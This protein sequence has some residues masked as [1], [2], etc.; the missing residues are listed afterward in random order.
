[1]RV[2][3]GEKPYACSWDGCGYRAVSK[4]HVA[5]HERRHSR[6]KKPFKCTWPGCGYLAT[7]KN[8]L[9]EHVR[10]HTGEKRTKA[11]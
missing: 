6:M 3:I 10:V 11:T 2:N 1:M 4:S 8:K 7:K 5:V 9:T